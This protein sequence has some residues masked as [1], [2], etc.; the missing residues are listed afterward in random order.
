MIA[1]YLKKAREYEETDGMPRVIAA[2]EEELE[3]LS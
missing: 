2:L 3:R 1:V